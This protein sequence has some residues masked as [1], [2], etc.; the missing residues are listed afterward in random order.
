MIAS[1]Y[2]PPAF[3]TLS[4]HQ[5]P[6]NRCSLFFLNTFKTNQ[7]VVVICTKLM[8]PICFQLTRNNGQSAFVGFDLKVVVLPSCEFQSS[9][10]GPHTNYRNTGGHGG[11]FKLQ[12]IKNEY[13]FIINILRKKYPNT[14]FVKLF[15]LKNTESKQ[16]RANP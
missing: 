11:L 7:F 13:K 10:L 15:R 14:Q 3:C 6:V 12:L 16:A 1:Y 4:C 5:L 8:D 9:F 2:S